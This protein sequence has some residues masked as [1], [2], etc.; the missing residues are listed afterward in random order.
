MSA[1]VVKRGAGRL[2]GFHGLQ[3]IG[4]FG[5]HF[6]IQVASGSPVPARILLESLE[7]LRLWGAASLFG[8]KKELNPL[9]MYSCTRPRVVHYNKLHP[10]SRQCMLYTVIHQEIPAHR[11]IG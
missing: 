5:T 7:V 11:V 9:N 4:P 2:Q 10:N 1:R 6:P 8:D 3:V